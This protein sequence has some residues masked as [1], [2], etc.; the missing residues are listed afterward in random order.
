MPT[1]WPPTLDL[2][3]TMRLP[4]WLRSDDQRTIRLAECLNC[5]KVKIDSD[6][7]GFDHLAALMEFA[8]YTRREPDA[9]PDGD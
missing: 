5:G 8:D 9:D 1:P 3:L 6:P 4:L 2:E 7:C